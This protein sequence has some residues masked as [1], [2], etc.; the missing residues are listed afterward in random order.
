MRWEK[1]ASEWMKE[2]MISFGKHSNAQQEREIHVYTTQ[3]NTHIKLTLHCIALHTLY[4][5][6]WVWLRPENLR[7]YCCR[8]CCS[9]CCRYWCCCFCA[10][11]S[12]LTWCYISC[13]SFVKFSNAKT[14]SPFERIIAGQFQFKRVKFAYWIMMNDSIDTWDTV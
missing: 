14:Y 5:N 10:V 12:I 3:A 6:H 9:C 11:Y 7:F 2:R 8:R 13:I 4:I 1:W